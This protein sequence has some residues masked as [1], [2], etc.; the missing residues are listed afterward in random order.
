M[1]LVDDVGK[2]GAFVLSKIN[3]RTKHY[4]V[5]RQRLNQAGTLMS[6]RRS[7]QR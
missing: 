6:D 5:A 4:Q 3:R 2:R 7:A 1:S